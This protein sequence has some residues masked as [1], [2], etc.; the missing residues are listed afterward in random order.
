MK[1]LDK[2]K[3]IILKNFKRLSDYVLDQLGTFSN[4]EGVYQ[5]LP[6]KV[7]KI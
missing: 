5:E 1:L 4:S 6:K 2:N 3:K 7:V